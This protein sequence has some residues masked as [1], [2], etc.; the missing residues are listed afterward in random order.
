V[1]SLER[2]RLNDYPEKE[3]RWGEIPH[4]EVPDPLNIKG[5]DIV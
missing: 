1:P 3:Y 5:E 4:L 2:G